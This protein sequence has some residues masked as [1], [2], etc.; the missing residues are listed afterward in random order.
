MISGINDVLAGKIAGTPAHT[1]AGDGIRYDFG[2][3]GVMR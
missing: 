2:T 3:F 1:F